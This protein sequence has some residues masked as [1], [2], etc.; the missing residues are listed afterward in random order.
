[1]DAFEGSLDLNS[2]NDT[3]DKGDTAHTADSSNTAT[4]T[5]PT[6]A[7]TSQRPNS[8][9]SSA[10]ASSHWR[11]TERFLNPQSS[12]FF[13]STP[14]RSTSPIPSHPPAPAT[15]PSSETTLRSYQA[16]P[17]N[18]VSFFTPSLE[19]FSRP[20]AHRLWNPVN[21]SPRVGIT[22]V[23]GRNNNENINHGNDNLDRSAR[24]QLAYAPRSRPQTTEESYKSSK[25]SNYGPDTSNSK[26]EI[27]LKQ[28]ATTTIDKNDRSFFNFEDEGIDQNNNIGI[29]NNHYGDE[30]DAINTHN[31]YKSKDLT[32]PVISRR[33]QSDK[34][35][36]SLIVEQHSTSGRESE[37]T[38]I[39]LLRNEEYNSYSLN[40]KKNK[41]LDRQGILFTTAAS[42]DTA[43]DTASVPANTPTIDRTGG[44]P[45]Q[46]KLR[47][48]PIANGRPV[49][50]SGVGYDRRNGQQEN[51]QQSNQRTYSLSSTNA[52][53]PDDLE[54]GRK[55]RRS[56]SRASM[57]LSHN[58]NLNYNNNNNNN[59]STT[60]GPI[61]NGNTMN[62]N[63]TA[64]TA[65]EFRWGPDHP[66]FPHLNPHVPLS[67]PLHES[68][69]IIRIRRNWMAHGD[70]APQFAN[71]YPEILDTHMAEEQFRQVVEHINKELAEAFSPW[72]TRA[73]VDAV[74]GALT[75]WIWEDLGMAGAKKRLERLEAWIETWNKEHGAK[76]D[77]E[78]KD[79]NV[80]IVP[81]RRTGYM[82]VSCKNSPSFFSSLYPILFFTRYIH[83]SDTKY[84]N[85]CLL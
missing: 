19:S 21:S 72:R 24:V 47:M 1:M 61:N 41:K 43:T 45:S 13:S 66:C 77:G 60:N 34:K 59:I 70:V 48:D 39:S 85:K 62:N 30:D 11:L 38:S 31:N 67:S 32:L 4:V 83:T 58:E 35:A 53:K 18:L 69:R 15:A 81:L 7:A 3:T 2:A 27:K 50:D 51:Q 63:D 16:R 79:G 76:G 68:T 25:I 33:K 52:L 44:K 42:S 22:S 73:W 14:P 28:R 65:E 6:T 8:I 5:A 84:T 55:I 36:G 80:W 57:P 74:M 56:V 78:V 26:T 46:H 29:V 37:N 49:A 82:T 12:F 23:A 40:N 64:S 10:S 71:L 9:T 17:Q 75:G 20:P 54:A